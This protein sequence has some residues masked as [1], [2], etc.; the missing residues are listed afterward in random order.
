MVAHT[1]AEDSAEELVRKRKLRVKRKVM[2]Y[3]AGTAGEVGCL[4]LRKEIQRCV[5]INPFLGVNA[6]LPC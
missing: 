4:N 3:W 6:T 2:G 1:R 5:D